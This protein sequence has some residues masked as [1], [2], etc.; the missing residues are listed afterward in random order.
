MISVVPYYFSTLFLASLQFIGI[1]NRGIWLYLSFIFA[2]VILPT[3]EYLF[4]SNDQYN[5][6]ESDI[7]IL[8]K[9]V[10]FKIITMIY[11]FLQLGIILYCCHF[12]NIT[13]N[14]QFYEFVGLVFSISSLNG[15]IGGSVSHELIHRS[16]FLELF[17]GKLLLVQIFYGYFFV[18]HLHG[19]HK[20]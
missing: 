17:L 19:H 6:S 14:L 13:K 15:G 10:R 20:L 3:S 8:E 4:F 11:P 12:V 9:Q 1:Y 16:S 18:E 5:P 7:K 2:F